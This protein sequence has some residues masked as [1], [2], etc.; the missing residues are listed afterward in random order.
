MVDR[1]KLERATGCQEPGESRGGTHVPIVVLLWG[2]YVPHQGSSTGVERAAKFS[3][4]CA[5]PYQGGDKRTIGGVIGMSDSRGDEARSRARKNAETFRMLVAIDAAEQLAAAETQWAQARESF[6]QAV[7]ALYR[8][9][10]IP[11]TEIAKLVGRSQSS[12]SKLVNR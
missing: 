2:T 8:I 3:L 9:D 5:G 4:K 12:I 7:V 1:A 11:Q 6:R 10:K